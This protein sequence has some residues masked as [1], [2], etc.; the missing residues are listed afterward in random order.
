MTTSSESEE[1]ALTMICVTFI[2]QLACAQSVGNSKSTQ[3]GITEVCWNAHVPFSVAHLKL[4]SN[5]SSFMTHVNM[6][7]HTQ[8]GN[9]TVIC[10]HLSPELAQRRLILMFIGFLGDLTA[11]HVCMFS[12]QDTWHR[13]S[14]T[15]RPD[16]CAWRLCKV[17]RSLH[18][19][20]THTAP[21]TH[22]H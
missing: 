2:T 4:C 13:I 10:P 21:P 5:T 20:T 22:S 7:C 18:K 16:T 14:M 12:K 11:G 15:P 6:E 9:F 19:I 3:R 1:H 17:L 8:M